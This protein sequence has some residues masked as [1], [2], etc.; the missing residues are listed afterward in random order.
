[1]VI[2]HHVV[3]HLALECIM[4]Y[5]SFVCGSGVFKDSS[6]PTVQYLHG[7]CNHEYI[8]GTL[9]H[10]FYYVQEENNAF[11][12]HAK[13]VVLFCYQYLLSEPA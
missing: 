5:I 9:Y 13:S 8:V 2:K 1:M 11:F 3:V 7:L 10:G 12:F 6:I 4:L